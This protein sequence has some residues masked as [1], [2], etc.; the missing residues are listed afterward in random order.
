MI[1]TIMVWKQEAILWVVV[2]IV[3]IAIMN[4]TFPLNTVK[5]YN[6]VVNIN[7]Y[8]RVIIK[9]I[10]YYSNNNIIIIKKVLNIYNNNKC[11]YNYKFDRFL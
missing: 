8:G 7:V 9:K 1:L 3:V 10:E 4:A 2:V 6:L 11:E 5:K